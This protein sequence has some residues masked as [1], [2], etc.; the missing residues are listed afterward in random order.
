MQ[1]EISNLL[2]FKQETEERGTVN[3]NELTEKVLY[4][5]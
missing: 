2:L 4:T 1:F 5:Y 3:L